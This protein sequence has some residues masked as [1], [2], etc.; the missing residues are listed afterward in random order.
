[1][2]EFEGGQVKMPLV[3]WGTLARGM[4]AWAEA[5]GEGFKMRMRVSG[6]EVVLS[7]DAFIVLYRALHQLLNGAE[8]Q[9]MRLIAQVGGRPVPEGRMANPNREA[10]LRAYQQAKL[11]AAGWDVLP[12]VDG[13]EGGET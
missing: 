10:T 1:M 5:S 13:E 4:Y 12:L 6:G 9:A 3:E 2:T 11:T 7:F 8:Q